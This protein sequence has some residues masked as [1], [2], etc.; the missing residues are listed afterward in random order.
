MKNGKTAG[1]KKSTKKPL[2]KSLSDKNLN[3]G[4]LL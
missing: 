3:R 4:N 2:S 1:S